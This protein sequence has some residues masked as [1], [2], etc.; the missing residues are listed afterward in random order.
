MRIF[1]NSN[2]IVIFR[3]SF[4]PP[5]GGHN[6]PLCWGLGLGLPINPGVSISVFFKNEKVQ[7]VIMSSTGFARDIL[8]S[9]I[10]L[11][12]SLSHS[13]LACTVSEMRLVCKTS[14]PSRIPVSYHPGIWMII[15]LAFKSVSTLCR[16]ASHW[17]PV[18][19]HFHA[20]FSFGVDNIPWSILLACFTSWIEIWEV[21][22][23]L[24]FLGAKRKAKALL[25]HVLIRNINSAL[26]IW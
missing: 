6:L 3:N 12:P 14:G 16:P 8:Y 24:A 7:N 10:W 25:R 22:L 20:T 15:P 11:S 2:S 21:L 4:L 5:H 23:W 9:M 18:A 1:G 26:I 17:Y 19:F 13:I